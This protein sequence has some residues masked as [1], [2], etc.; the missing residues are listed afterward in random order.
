MPHRCNPAPRRVMGSIR[1]PRS[2]RP[3]LLRAAFLGAALLPL[4]AWAGPSSSAADSV[5]IERGVPVDVT[6]ANAAQARDRAIA[7]AEGTALARLYAKLTPDADNRQPP[8]LS[9]ADLERLVSGFEVEGER[10]SSVRYVGRMTIAFRP[11]AVRQLLLRSGARY[12]EVVGKPALILPLD[13]TGTEPALWTDGPW[14][15]AWLTLTAGGGALDGLLPLMVAAPETQD[16]TDLPARAAVNPAPAV[17]AQLAQ[18]HGAGM[19]VVAKL[20]GDAGRGYQLTLLPY[21]A[22]GQPGEGVQ[23]AQTVAQT[24][25]AAPPALP[26]A[27]GGK[28]AATALPPAVLLQAVA[29]AADRLQE[30]WKRRVLIDQPGESR[31]VLELPLPVPPPVPAASVAAPAAATPAPAPASAPVPPAAD[32]PASPPVGLT[33]LVDIRHRLARVPTVLRVDTTSLRTDRAVL[34][35]S[36]RGDIAHLRTALAQSDLSLAATPEPETTDHYQLRLTT[37]G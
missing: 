23:A 4:A 6:A 27:D 3:A 21:L 5:F 25:F 1:R 9:A 20:E 34:A 33:T 24:A 13:L 35:I 16:Q 22:P 26:G 28:P 30:D 37:G 7:Q 2:A 36:F 29:T 32:A 18:R 11:D 8:A 17:L 12:A 15:Q 19:V 10:A 31:A 14:R